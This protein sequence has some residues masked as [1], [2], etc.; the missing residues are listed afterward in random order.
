M[1][2]P[3]PS[4]SSGGA[5]GNTSTACYTPAACARSRPAAISPRPERLRPEQLPPPAGA[6]EIERAPEELHLPRRHREPVDLG[7]HA[8]AVD[9]HALLRAE[10]ADAAL[11][12]AGA[13]AA[14]LPAA[15]QHL[16]DRVIDQ[17]VV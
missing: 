4:R 14:L 12:V 15:H 13:D 9:D 2:C 17:H 11:A 10:L 6:E 7:L 1:R 3:T 16:G 8:E 5:W